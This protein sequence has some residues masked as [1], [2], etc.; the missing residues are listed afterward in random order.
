M[1]DFGSIGNSKVALSRTWK[2]FRDALKNKEFNFDEIE[3]AKNVTFLK[4]LNDLFYQHK[5]IDAVSKAISDISC[6]MGRGTILNDTEKVDHDRFLPKKQFITSANR[7]S[8]KGVEWLYLALDNNASATQTAKSEIR[9]SEGQRFGFCYFEFG[10]DAKRYKI[11]DLTIADEYEYDDFNAALEAYA[12]LKLEKEIRKA[13][14]LRRMPKKKDIINKAEF[15]KVFVEWS[16]YTYCK[17]LSEE[18]FVP[19]DTE[20]RDLAYAPFQ[21][22]ATYF[23]SIGYSGIIYKSTVQNGGKNIVLFDKRLAHPMGE[24]VDEVIQ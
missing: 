12:Q 22:M 3:K 5:G 15:E 7:F 9:I 6:K 11:V 14:L 24:I 23:L 8:P 19:L 16:I 18:I 17:L 10:E 20:D 1:F 21:T 2:E 13:K 4:V